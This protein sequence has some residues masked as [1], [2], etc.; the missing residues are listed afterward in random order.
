MHLRGSA[1]NR[2][3]PARRAAITCCHVTRS[4]GGRFSSLPAAF[5][6]SVSVVLCGAGAVFLVVFFYTATSNMTFKRA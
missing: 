4:R 5:S 3:A 2:A 1:A 6:V